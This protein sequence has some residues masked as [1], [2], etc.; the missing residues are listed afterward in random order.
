MRAPAVVVFVLAL[1]AA[2]GAASAQDPDEAVMLAASGRRDAIEP[3]RPMTL[4]NAPDEAGVIGRVSVVATGVATIA[5]ELEIDAPAPFGAATLE[6]VDQTRA[7]IGRIDLEGTSGV[8][9]YWS[10]SYPNGFAT[11]WL[12]APSLPAGIRIEVVGLL[13]P[14]SNPQPLSVW[15]RG[16]PPQFESLADV[17]LDDPALAAVGRAIA[18]LEVRGK[19]G[20]FPCTGFLV[21]ANK[22]LTNAHCLLPKGVDLCRGSYAYF[23]YDTAG[24]RF[25]PPGMRAIEC[26][27]YLAGSDPADVSLDYALVELA[28]PVGDERGFLKLAG[29]SPVPALAL[30]VPQHPDGRPLAFARRD[31]VSDVNPKNGRGPDTDFGHT[32][33]TQGGSS[34]SPML[35]AS[36]QVVGLHH[37]GRHPNES[38]D[39]NRAVRIERIVADLRRR[40][41]F[42]AEQEAP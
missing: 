12:K 18:R 14:T 36:N 29:A 6:F 26:K 23:G 16:T 27:R 5:V 25:P 35:D 42:P 31:C 32:C 37:W 4:S 3:P 15:P 38:Y 19:N 7:V 33:D 2:P 9:R 1:F 34:G 20:A 21:G 39:K 17:A 40:G 24:Q 13:K 22:L 41:L 11:V 28:E 8:E 10:P 30:R